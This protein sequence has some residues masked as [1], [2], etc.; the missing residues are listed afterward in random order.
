MIMR[1][2]NK[3][4]TVREVAYIEKIKKCYNIPLFI[5]GIYPPKTKSKK[6]KI[7]VDENSERG[8]AVYPKFISLSDDDMH[9]ISKA[10]SDFIY[11]AVKPDGTGD[12]KGILSWDF[13]FIKCYSYVEKNNFLRKLFNKADSESNLLDMTMGVV[14]EMRMPKVNLNSGLLPEDS[15][16]FNTIISLGIDYDS[17]LE[18]YIISLFDN[19]NNFE[20]TPAAS[21]KDTISKQG[22]R[23][24]IND[25]KGRYIDGA[26]QLLGL[27]VSKED[28]DA[29]KL[30]LLL[31]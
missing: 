4:I 30:K 22:A 26:L 3:L 11:N 12:D 6:L 16:Y 13:S 29:L 17:D 24:L 14:K 20:E 7:F 15:S 5:I 8:V 19:E 31:D 10:I 9:D 18:K 21:R 28:I 2:S 27:F 1:I 25:F 23:N